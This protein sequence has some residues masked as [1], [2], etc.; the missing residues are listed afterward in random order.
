MRMLRA[1]ILSMAALLITAATVLAADQASQK[2]DGKTVAAKSVAPG[3]LRKL[4]VTAFEGR[5]APSTLRVKAG[6]R[7]QI[8]FFSKDASYGIKFKDF[9][10]SARVSKE[11]PAV[12]EFTPNEKGT[13]QFRCGKTINLKKWTENGTLIVE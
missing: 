6:E 4:H 5:I 7:V 13:F 1:T 12:V 10:V 9:D 11:K 2:G 8:T 3:Q